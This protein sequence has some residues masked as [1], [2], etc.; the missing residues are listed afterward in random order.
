MIKQNEI[1]LG[2][3]IQEPSGNARKIE[4]TDLI[5][6]LFWEEVKKGVHVGIGINKLPLNDLNEVLKPFGYYFDSPYLCSDY[7][8]GDGG[9]HLIAP[10]VYVH[11]L[12]NLLYSLEGEELAINELV[13]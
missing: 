9:T 1:R 3:L 7:S 2:V 5:E 10:V 13:P 11:Q 8:E 12:Q 6:P 4:L